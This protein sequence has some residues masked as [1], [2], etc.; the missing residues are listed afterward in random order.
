[1]SGINF[2]AALAAARTIAQ[3]DDIARLLWRAHAQGEIPDE[4]A[5]AV[6]EAAQARRAAFGPRATIRLAAAAP[7]YVRRLRPRSPDRQ[8]SLERRR[9]CATSGV[10]P[11]PIAA[12]FTMGELAALSIIGDEVRKCQSCALFLD[13]IAGKAGVS[14]TTAQNAVRLAERLGLIR[15]QERRRPGARSWSNIITIISREWR[16]WLRLDAGGRPPGLKNLS[17]TNNLFS[18]LYLR[19]RKSSARTPWAA[20]KRRQRRLGEKRG[21]KPQRALG[22]R[23]AGGARRRR[24]RL[25][26]AGGSA[27][28]GEPATVERD[29]ILARLHICA[30]MLVR[31]YGGDMRII[32]LVTQKGGSGKSTLAASL[33]VAASQA[34]ETVICLDLD[35]QS[36]LAESAKLRKGEAPPVAHVPAAA[37]AGLAGMLAGV[38]GKYTLAIMDTAGADSPTTHAAMSAADLCLV[39]LRPTRPDALALQPTVAALIRSNK[40]FAFVLSQCPTGARSP[41]A[42]EMAAGLGTL[43]LLAEPPICLRTDHQDAYASGQGVTEFAPSGKAADEIRALWTWIKEQKQ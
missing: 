12:H 26:K 30:R 22:G 7:S 39:P 4:A 33:A 29:R 13:A 10:I 38:A 21:R 37:V 31:N 32:A 43:G 5:Q 3:V 17:P 42:A 19:R 6:A 41:R 27:R 18:F 24:R 2:G 25:S 8:R 1:M 15:R 16:A 23:L 20:S 9:R 11:S 34:G 35:P 36:T 40:K 14:R 28:G